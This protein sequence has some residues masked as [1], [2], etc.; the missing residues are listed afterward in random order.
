MKANVLK[1]FITLVSFF[2]FTSINLYAQ[3]SELAP[4]YERVDFIIK[5]INLQDVK[6][7]DENILKKNKVR[8]V[9]VH[10]IN[11][12]CDSILI[13]KEGFI[14]HRFYNHK[15]HDDCPMTILNL[16]AGETR[17]PPKKG[18]KYFQYYSY[19]ENNLLTFYKNLIL[20]YPGSSPSYTYIYDN[21][22]LQKS[23]QGEYPLYE[24]LYDAESGKLSGLKVY[25]KRQDPYECLIIYNKQN[26][27]KAFYDSVYGAN[28]GEVIFYADDTIKCLN[29]NMGD[30]ETFTLNENRIQ[31]EDIK[32]YNMDGYVPLHKQFVYR[33]D[34][35]VDYTIETYYPDRPIFKR[36]Y[37]YK[38]YEN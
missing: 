1:F 10:D 37:S 31:T 14:T 18:W 4:V 11:G 35:M 33:K 26:K 2:I 36:S 27:P 5:N 29:H 19:N 22:K 9:I 6:N 3:Y 32:L 23:F 30:I 13:N 7:N 16:D 28:R 12:V 8:E 24:C 21:G 38:F 25:S 17:P 34:G 20:E 15:W